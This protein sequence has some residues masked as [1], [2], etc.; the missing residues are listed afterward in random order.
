MIEL[1]TLYRT[2]ELYLKTL[3]KFLGPWFSSNVFN[4]DPPPPPNQ[5]QKYY[6]Y[7]NFVLSSVN[8]QLLFLWEDWHKIMKFIYL[9]PVTIMIV[10]FQ[11]KMKG[12]RPAYLCVVQPVMSFSWVIKY[13]ITSRF[14]FNP[15]SL[16]AELWKLPKYYP[17]LVGSNLFSLLFM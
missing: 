9:Q 2:Q 5:P 13:S 14:G 10:L 11:L 15:R 16:L 6:R 17:L 12:Q 8:L 4:I 1:F 7:N 3:N